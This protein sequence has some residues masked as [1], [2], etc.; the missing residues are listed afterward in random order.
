MEFERM[1]GLESND[2]ELKMRNFSKEKVLL[3]NSE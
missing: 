3:L 1:F 2:L